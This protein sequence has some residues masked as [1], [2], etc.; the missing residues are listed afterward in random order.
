[1]VHKMNEGFKV[2]DGGINKQYFGVI[3]HAFKALLAEW[4]IKWVQKA[5]SKKLRREVE[6]LAAAVVILFG[7]RFR[8]EEVLIASLEGML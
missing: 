8:I 7:G 4:Y 3:I 2:E 6:H 5:E 1:M